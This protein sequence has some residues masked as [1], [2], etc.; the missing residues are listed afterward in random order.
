MR[1][2]YIAEITDKGQVVGSILA[3]VWLW[4]S[5]KAG[6]RKINDSCEPCYGIINF[7]RVS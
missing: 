7:R 5:C 2:H 3:T 4:Q 1:K 6:Y